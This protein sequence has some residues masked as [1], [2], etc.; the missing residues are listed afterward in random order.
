MRRADRYRYERGELIEIARAI[1]R[2]AT[3]TAAGLIL[4][5]AATSPAPTP[6]A[7]TWSRATRTRAA[8]CASS[9]RRTT[10]RLRVARVHDAGLAQ[11]DRRRGGARAPA[12][13]HRRRVRARPTTC[14][15]A[16]TRS[17]DERIGYRTMSMLAV[18][19][20]S[21]RGRG[22][23]RDPADQQEA[24][25]AT[26]ELSAAEDF[27][28]EVVAVRRAQR[29]AAR[30]LA[31][32]A[33]IALE[34]ALLYEEIRSIFE[35]FVRASVQAIEQR[36]PTTSGHSLRVSVLS[37]RL[38]EQRR[39]ACAAA[40][41]ARRALQPPRPA[42][43]RVRRAAARL[44][45]DRRARA[46]AGQG[47]EALPAPARRDPRALRVR[48]QGGRGRAA[49][50]ASSTLIEQGAAQARPR[51]ARQ[52]ATRRAAPSCSTPGR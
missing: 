19:M 6:A 51:R 11:L 48:A 7:S 33:G 4:R 50:R 10:R 35:G 14:R 13:Q 12:D 37:V 25:P 52:A 40:P 38:A 23:R 39:P 32:Q 1:T 17:F 22:D 15:T 26:R 3:S 30:A 41:Y 42:G 49:A 27:D 24:R 8:R 46:G 16:S 43:A 29:G 34:N 47:Q 36:D 5:R 21:A 9:S 2:S 31:A 45:Q 20:I 18:P 44:R 28:A